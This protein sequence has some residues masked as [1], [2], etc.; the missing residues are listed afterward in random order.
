M[1]RQFDWMISRLSL[2]KVKVSHT[3]CKGCFIILYRL[4]ITK[5]K[6]WIIFDQNPWPPIITMVNIRHLGICLYFPGASCY[7]NVSSNSCLQAMTEW[8]LLLQARSN[9][10]PCS[11]SKTYSYIIL[12]CL[13][14]SR[15]SNSNCSII[16]PIL[17]VFSCYVW[18]KHQSWLLT[19]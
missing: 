4:T 17:N 1:W 2:S 12:A 11:R 13:F 7:V 18:I 16:V 5:E 8:A 19:V 14:F 3:C 6:I 15:N 9:T 10:P